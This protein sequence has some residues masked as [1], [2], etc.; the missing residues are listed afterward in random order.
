MKKKIKNNSHY[1]HHYF[2]Q[3]QVLSESYSSCRLTHTTNT[4]NMVVSAF[5]ETLHEPLLIVPFSKL[6]QSCCSLQSQTKTLKESSAAGFISLPL[7]VVFF[8]SFPAV[9]SL[10]S[11][12]AT[13]PYLHL[14]IFFPPSTYF[15]VRSRQ[16]TFTCT[17]R[18]SRSP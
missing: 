12:F 15:F 17:A 5:D 8:A 3:H 10:F 7:D 11:L 16:S 9:I 18:N 14:F 13:L 1:Y 6:F 2:I 4:H